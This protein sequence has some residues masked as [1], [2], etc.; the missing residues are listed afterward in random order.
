MNDNFIGI[1]VVDVL[2]QE[3]P[4]VMVRNES[5]SADSATG[6]RF[7][8]LFV[9]FLQELANILNFRYE[10]IVFNRKAAEGRYQSRDSRCIELV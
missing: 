2:M 1:L 5:H 4:F 7:E 6:D 10:L 9:D 8:G 3:E